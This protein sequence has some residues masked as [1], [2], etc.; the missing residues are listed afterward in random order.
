MTIARLLEAMVAYSER[1]I[2][3]IDRLIRV[4]TYAKTIGEPESSF[5]S[6]V[7]ACLWGKINAKLNAF[8]ADKTLGDLLAEC[9]EYQAES[10]D[11]Y[12]I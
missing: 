5:R 8:A 7:N 11:L 9:S 4:R 3:N 12:I 6:S 1:N 10:W 2:H